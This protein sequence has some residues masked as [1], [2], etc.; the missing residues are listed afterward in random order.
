MAMKIKILVVDDDEQIAEIVKILLTQ[1][2]CDTQVAHNGKKGLELASAQKFDLIVLDVNLP[3]INGFE[4]CREL[5]Q[6]HLSSRTPIVFMSGLSVEENGPKGRE[7]GA[8]D[9][10]MKPFRTDEFVRRLLVHVKTGA[11]TTR[12][13]Q[14]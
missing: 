8:V 11:E 14:L 4:I 5:K 13:D 2:D 7:A 6:R 9:Y 3:D 1:A 10:I 12:A